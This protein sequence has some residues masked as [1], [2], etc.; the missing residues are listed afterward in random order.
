MSASPDNSS[1]TRAAQ[2]RLP[3]GPFAVCQQQ[4]FEGNRMFVSQRRP[5][6]LTTESKEM[7]RRRLRRIKVPLP[8][9]LQHKIAGVALIDIRTMKS[10]TTV[11]LLAAVLVESTL[12]SQTRDPNWQ[13][14][15][16]QKCAAGEVWKECVS[17]GCGEKTCPPKKFEPCLST[18]EYGCYCAEGFFRN[19]KGRCIS[20]C[21]SQSVPE[22]PS[23]HPLPETW[24]L[25]PGRPLPHPQPGSHSR[26]GLLRPIRPQTRPEVYPRPPHITIL[27]GP[28]PQPILYPKP[29]INTEWN[30][31][32]VS[33]TLD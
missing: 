8:H 25:P 29:S 16:P 28:Q 7:L 17:R 14:P 24:F 2:Q 19:A 9:R 5:G 18:C 6:V 13:P 33:I 22:S 21:T 32:P 11:V 23:P 30:Q 12:A 1:S 20:E 26:P 3:C 10:A 31:K 27:P 4:L 15:K